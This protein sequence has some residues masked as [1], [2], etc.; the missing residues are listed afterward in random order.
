MGIILGRVLTNDLGYDIPKPL[1]QTTSNAV[2]T[3]HTHS[4][5]FNPSKSI[6]ESSLQSLWDFNKV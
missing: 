3:P 1:S 6:D 4:R 2:N 5:V